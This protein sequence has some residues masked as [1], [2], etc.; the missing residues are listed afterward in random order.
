[1]SYDKWQDSRKYKLVIVS[2]RFLGILL[3]ITL[4]ALFA[5]VI[6]GYDGVYVQTLAGIVLPLSGS[7]VT[8]LGFYFGANV[9]QKI[10]ER[11]RGNE[12]SNER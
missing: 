10:T 5:L 12:F 1:M 11:R 3:I 8:T 2:S 9:A 6:A 4:F 7:F